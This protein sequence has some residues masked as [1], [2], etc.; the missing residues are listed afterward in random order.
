MDVSYSDIVGKVHSAAW[1]DTYIN[2][3]SH[4]YIN[5]DTSEERKYECIKF[6]ADNNN[7]Y[8]LILVDNIPIGIIK[9]S[10]KQVDLCEIESIY[11]LDEY[12]GTGYGTQVIDYI[13]KI[14]RDYKII[15]WVL[16]L[17]HKAIRFYKKN[18]FIWDD[19]KRIIN[20]GHDYYQVKFVYDN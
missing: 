1:K 16:E 9:V 7:K 14:Y 20:R 19:T 12:R 6:L 10:I 13:K 8:Y 4:E 18:G 2:I 3:F 11:F 5:K 15:L 17:N